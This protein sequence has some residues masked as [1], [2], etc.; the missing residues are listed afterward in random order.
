[1]G[2]VLWRPLGAAEGIGDI[3]ALDIHGDPGPMSLLPEEAPTFDLPPVPPLSPT[4]ETMEEAMAT[5]ADEED[6]PN[7]GGDLARASMG[8]GGGGEK[9]FDVGASEKELL[10]LAR[11]VEGR[12]PD[13]EWNEIAAQ[14]Q[15]DRYVVQKGDWLWKISQRLFGSGFYYSKIW[16][17]NP[18]ITNPHD[19]EPGLVLLF[20]TGGP[21]AMPE[22]TLGTFEQGPQTPTG[23]PEGG[24]SPWILEREKLVQG[25][26]HFEYTPDSS[27]YEDLE[28][29]T[30]GLL[31]EE[32]KKY[33]PILP[34]SLR[35]RAK[36]DPTTKDFFRV[37]K[38]I[39][40][41]LF[42]NTF[43]TTNTLEDFGFID[44]FKDEKLHA[45]EHDLLFVRFL[46]S[47]DIDPGNTF[48]VY[49]PDGVIKSEVSDRQGQHYTIVA[50]LEAI[51]QIDDIWECRISQLSGIVERN[52]RV[53]SYV[54]PVSTAAR[55]FAKRIIEAAIIASQKGLA[56]VST[57]DIIHI[58]RGRLDG[59]EVGTVFS[60]YDFFDRG[61]ERRITPSPTY[62]IGELVVINVTDNFATAFVSEALTAIQV[63]HLAFTTSEEEALALAR[64]KERAKR[65]PMAKEEFDALE[66]LD[67]ELSVENLSDNLLK[68]ADKIQL[69]R[70]EL[71]ELQRQEQASS[72]L[73]EHERDLLELEKLEKEISVAES[74]LDELRVDEDK[75][76]EQQDLDAIERAAPKDPNAFKDINEIEK[77]IGRKYMDEDINS[78]ENPYGLTEFDL[79]EIDELLNTESL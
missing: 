46:P 61:T 75:F 9:S 54:P 64:E 69:S 68:E 67:V 29:L 62:R 15:S 56:T 41:G 4:E 65:G 39:K 43:I 26:A 5:I 53:T 12:I 79:E 20:N 44:S 17:L 31:S 34:K 76:L 58:D 74:S 8:Q 14:A 45:N 63:G 33:N 42:P 52:D 3:N 19:I 1:M 50:K 23:T 78:S 55:I 38:T 18:Q 27:T 22:V 11:F 2:L 24:A 72:V 28:A 25:G 35:P 40:R 16:S 57:G 6:P 48:S 32:H 13:N 49:R 37:Q 21:N 71:E 47:V 73:K 66:D 10:R 51:R 59:V 70:G 30:L 77:D 60:I 7:L 36:T